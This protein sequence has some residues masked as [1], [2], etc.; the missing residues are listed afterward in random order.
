MTLEA[1]RA[2]Q[3][4]LFLNNFKEPNMIMWRLRI[5]QKE[6]KNEM[7][8][9]NGLQSFRQEVNNAHISRIILRTY[10]DDAEL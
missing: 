3:Q 6:D 4:V 9:G 2:P 8:A 5:S 10:I 1:Q 7:N